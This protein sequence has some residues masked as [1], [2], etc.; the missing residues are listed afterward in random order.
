MFFEGVGDASVRY[1]HIL[2]FWDLQLLLVKLVSI[3][4]VMKSL[5]GLRIL[6]SKFTAPP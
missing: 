4:Y 1:A 3:H 5:L 6:W 2:K